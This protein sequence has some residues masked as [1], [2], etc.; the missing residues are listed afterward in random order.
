[1]TVA[2]RHPR[3]RGITSDNIGEQFIGER[4]NRGF[5]TLLRYADQAGRGFNVEPAPP[6][7][8]CANQDPNNRRDIE[9]EKGVGFSAGKF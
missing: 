1:M 4:K 8:Y 2:L 9:I 7:L 3:I 6:I 5:V